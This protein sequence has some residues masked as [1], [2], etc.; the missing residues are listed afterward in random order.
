MRGLSPSNGG[1]IPRKIKSNALEDNSKRIMSIHDRHLANGINGNDKLPRIMVNLVEG[2]NNLFL[3]DSGASLSI[4]S[5]RT[6]EMAKELGLKYKHIARQTKISTISGG[7]INYSSVAEINFT[8][9]GRKFKHAFFIT[10]QIDYEKL[11]QGLIGT[12]FLR[13]FDCSIHLTSN[14]L[15]IGNREIGFYDPDRDDTE[16]EKMQSVRIA[17]KIDLEPGES[18]EVL[19]KG[20]RGKIEQH[21]LIPKKLKI[22]HL[23][24]NTKV[25]GKGDKNYVKIHNNSNSKITLNKRT[26]V[27]YIKEKGTENNNNKGSNERINTLVDIR[28]RRTQDFSIGD[29]KF[30]ELPANKKLNFRELVSKYKDIFSK[31]FLTIGET[32]I[33]EPHIELHHKTPISQK[34]LP[35]PF[36]LKERVK[37]ELDSLSEAGIIRKSNSM[38][39]SPMVVVHKKEADKL[40]LVC[41][42]RLLNRIAVSDTYPLPRIFEILNS[43]SGSK[44]FAKMDLH[45]AF[46]QIAIPP[47]LRHLFGFCSELGFWEY[48]RLPFGYKNSS[49]IFQ[50]MM[51]MV[52]GDLK[53]RK[54]ITY[55]DDII[56]G[57]Q[58]VDEL[59]EKIEIVFQRLRENNLTIS[60][61]KCV[62]GATKI[63]FLGY[64]VS[65]SELSPTEDNARKILEFNIPNTVKKVK[66]FLGTCNFY[67]SLIP[68]YAELAKPLTDLTCKGARFQ[69]KDA[70][71]IQNFKRL[72]NAF[73]NPP[74]LRQPDFERPFVITTDAS[75]IAI[76]GVLEQWDAT[77]QMF[78]PIAYYSRAL[79]P[80]ETRYAPIK[81]E[82]MAVHN[83]VTYFKGYVYGSKFEVRSDA[84]PLK[85]FKNQH[86]PG[87]LVTRWLLELADYDFEIKHIK[88]ADNHL[89]DYISRD[90][91][92]RREEPQTVRENMNLIGR[93]HETGH[94]EDSQKFSKRTLINSVPLDSQEYKTQQLAEVMSILA[95]MERANEK[96][97]DDAEEIGIV[98]AIHA[99]LFED[100]LSLANIKEL[101]DDDLDIKLIKD[102]IIEGEILNIPNFQNYS[103]NSDNGLLMYRTEK[104]L[105][106]DRYFNQPKIVVPTILRKE[107]LER[108]HSAHYGQLKTFNLVRKHFYWAGYFKDVENFVESCWECMKLKGKIPRQA[109]AEMP[110][111]TKNGEILSLDI[112]GPFKQ[113]PK[114]NKYVLTIIDQFSRFLQLYPLKTVSAEEV[115]D[116]L[117]HY[118]SIFGAP[119]E[120]LTDNGGAFIAHLQR[121]IQDVFGIKPNFTSSYHPQ[122]NSKC[123]RVHLQ[124]KHCIKARCKEDNQW[125]DYIYLHAALYNANHHKSMGESP[126]FVMFGMDKAKLINYGLEERDNGVTLRS[127]TENRVRNVMENYKKAYENLAMAQKKMCEASQYKAKVRN[128]EIGSRV[129][130]KE[131]RTNFGKSKFIGPYRVLQQVNKYV[132]RLQDIEF[133]NKPLIKVNIDR[134]FQIRDRKKYLRDIEHIDR[135]LEADLV[136]LETLDRNVQEVDDPQIVLSY[137]KQR[138]IEPGESQRSESNL[139]I[140]EVNNSGEIQDLSD[141]LRQNGTD[142]GTEDGDVIDSRNIAQ[143]IDTIPKVIDD[144]N[145]SIDSSY[146][147]RSRVQTN[148][149]NNAI[150]PKQLAADENNR[151][152]LRSR[153]HKAERQ[154]Q[155]GIN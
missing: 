128:I 13:A 54:I 92:I 23:T 114:G 75:K 149:K 152:N 146:F 110:I 143:N 53:E 120:V 50:R 36:R 37:Q 89:A 86:N 141:H 105:T 145:Q 151:Y 97:S 112:C 127:Y 19:I 39:A 135:S 57:A 29:F 139:N 154:N 125:E 133:P 83:S 8:I 34:P 27:G 40:R 69:P 52:F 70:T 121:R 20:D 106:Q 25:Y 30:D 96:Q 148:P 153:I 18:R 48:A 38:Y 63:D 113:T 118:I 7:T 35:I 144:R 61:S 103:L 78:H 98:N 58:S 85:E 132:F 100:K 73:F 60:P 104:N 111:C 15:Q 87:N 129:F 44:F 33:L 68:K 46:H 2:T 47:K 130:I 82:L 31:S 109:L 80:A 42:F 116:K 102:A 134:I 67:R 51:D 150:V 140:N 49:N 22:H 117:I 55:V 94:L 5:K 93:T 45:A 95:D 77:S 62:F 119:R 74:L 56:I 9:N 14:I 6:F 1:D 17:R 16:D 64:R 91:L 32:K 126:D 138:V 41:D 11:Y 107:V 84:E 24:V 59:Y 4:L 43:L 142:E 26:I 79:N 81:L 72:Q 124:L 136:Q 76:S 123:E 21:L 115:A 131:G 122:T 12:D 65:E 108:V 99:T 147:L 155:A 10:N 66:S 101:Q 3:I 137:G 28:E 71:Y 88:G 90:P